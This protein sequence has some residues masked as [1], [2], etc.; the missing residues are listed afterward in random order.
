MPC[1]R[2]KQEIVPVCLKGLE[3]PKIPITVIQQSSQGDKGQSV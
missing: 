2:A 1:L 3:T